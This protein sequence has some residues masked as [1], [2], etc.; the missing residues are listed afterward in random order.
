MDDVI[1]FDMYE[2]LEIIT[3]EDT[4]GYFVHAGYF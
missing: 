3:P 1:P 2:I 4:E